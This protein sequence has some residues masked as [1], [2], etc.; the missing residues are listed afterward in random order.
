MKKML[1][2]PT[3]ALF[4]A[5]LLLCALRGDAQLAAQ[6]WICHCIAQLLTLCSVGSFRNASAREPGVRRVDRRFSGTWPVI[7]LGGALGAVIGFFMGALGY[8]GDWRMAWCAAMLVIIEQLFE[9]RMFALSRNA[10]GVV[11]S[12]ISNVLLL[13][14]LMLD[15]SGGVGAP[16]NLAGFYT[17]CGAGLGAVIS[18]VAAYALEPMRAFSL[19]PRN[20]G[21]FPKAAAQDLLYPAAALGIAKMAT[22]I[23][24]ALL[25]TI[26]KTIGPILLGMILW[27]L[28]R[29]VCRRAS[30]ESRALNLLLIA[31]CALTAML[32]L[33]LPM[34]VD[35]SY[36]VLTYFALVCAA[37]VFCA[38]G[39][40]LYAGIVL[41]YGSVYFLTTVKEE[42]IICC[43]C[44]AVAVILNLHKAF[45]R[46]V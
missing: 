4:P 43:A 7:L 23:D 34:P 36:V 29:T 46:K 10:D 31:V 40:R 41:L 25:G 38:P 45:L 33:W 14:G 13:A 9:E 42:Q 37:I 19:I 12:V 20:I 32:V 24:D 30:D 17:A 1:M 5:V 16:G 3:A 18:I 11:L 44:A 21:F 22:W 39:W 28:S 15:S 6:M 35:A 8:I 26:Q 2:R 27:R